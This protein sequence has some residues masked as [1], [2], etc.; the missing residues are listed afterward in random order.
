MLGVTEHTEE[1]ERKNKLNE[2]FQRKGTNSFDFCTLSRNFIFTQDDSYAEILYNISH[3]LVII[4]F[5]KHC[6]NL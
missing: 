2:S 6:I 1:Q 4:D 5:T 3:K